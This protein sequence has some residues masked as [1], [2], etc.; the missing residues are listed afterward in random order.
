MI[1]DREW[2]YLAPSLG[3]EIAGHQLQQARAALGGGQDV[4][5]SR[6]QLPLVRQAEATLEG[7]KLD[8]SYTQI[9]APLAGIVTR[10]VVPPLRDSISNR[11]PI[12]FTRSCMLG[13]P[14]PGVS[15]TAPVCF[16]S[17]PGVPGP[18]PSL[19]V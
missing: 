7:A 2:R 17:L 19:S 15:G 13:M 9:L 4:D 3:D 6:Y 14:T 10:T 18:C 5:H 8:L 11:P 16:L 12:C 1:P